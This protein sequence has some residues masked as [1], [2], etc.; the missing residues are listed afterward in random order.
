MSPTFSVPP[1]GVS[2]PAIIR[3]SVV[4]P[5]PFGPTTPTMPAGG[6]ENVRSST[7]SRSPKPFCRCSAS[8][9]RSPSRGPGGM[10]ISTLSSF[11]F[12]SSASSFSYAPRRAF[13]FA[14]R[15]RRAH[16]NPLE[17]ARERAAARRLRLLLDR[18]PRLLLLEP[19]RVVALERNALAAVE[20]EDPARDVV[21]EVPIVGDGDDRALV[22]GEEA[23]EPRDRLRVEMVRRLVEQQ[24]A[25]R[26][27]QQPAERDAAALAAGERRDV[28]V[29]VRQAQR[30]HR[31][32]EV[33]LELPCVGAVDRVLHL[34]LVGEQRVVVGVRLGERGRDLVEAVEQVAQLAHAVLDV[35]AHVLLGIEI[36]LLLEEADRRA[37][38]ELRDAGGR[39]LLA[40]HDPQQRRLAG[41]V[42]PEHADLRAGQERQGDVRQHLAVRAVELVG[43]VH[44]V[45]VV[46]AHFGG[47]TVVGVRCPS[48]PV[49]APRSEYRRFF[50]RK[51]AAKD[52]RRY[53][54]A[55][56]H[57]DGAHAR[58]SSRA[59]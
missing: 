37:G 5:A 35:A 7:S 33:L 10:C 48:W 13:D 55:R 50:S 26:R 34:R 38:R 40:R 6:S 46:A 43:P 56:P 32:V 44:R 52:A 2:W 36:R 31:V 14:C 23:L 9:T 57:R 18:E 25:G 58:P 45:D 49:A 59:T 16:A 22:V 53:R 19:R 41:A 51:V 11:T 29:A 42:R 8:I 27:E 30:V 15:A 28:A 20:L 1:S 54:E 12:C 24:Q 39:L 47:A 17:L 3:K 21:E 4:L